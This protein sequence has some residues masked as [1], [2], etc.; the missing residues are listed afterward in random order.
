MGKNKKTVKE[1]LTEKKAAKATKAATKSAAKSA[2]ETKVETQAVEDPAPKETKE[3]KSKEKPATEAPKAETK[4]KKTS[5]KEKSGEKEEVLIPEE[6]KPEERKQGGISSEVS[7]SHVLN[8]SAGGAKID[9]NHAIDLMKMVREDYVSNPDVKKENPELAGVMV[10]QYEM[11]K[12]LAI[13]QYNAQVEEDFQKLG[14]KVTMPQF[15]EMEIIA[16]QTLGIQ[17]KSLPIPGNDKQL[18]ID[19]EGSEIPKE[20][21]EAARKEAKAAKLEIPEPDAKLPEAEKLTVLRTIFAQ[22]NGIGNNLAAA[23]E[24]ARK[25]FSFEETERKS[26]ILANIVNKGAGANMINC[27]RGMTIGK[28]NS[29]HSLL[30]AHALLKAWCPTYSDKEIAEI[31]QVLST[32]A[33]EKKIQDWNEKAD[34][35][36]KTTLDKELEAVHRQIIAGSTETIINAILNKKDK[37]IT[38]VKENS[39]EIAVDTASIRKSMVAAYGD[40]DNLLKDKLNEIVQYYVKPIMRL[41]NYVDKSAYAE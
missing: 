19:F 32:M 27:L 22:R 9:P 23:I 26:V 13:L 16:R 33:I 24:W 39:I 28:L 35:G 10:K 4:E 5:K 3:E 31:M 30:G 2:T 20:V 17:L 36:R 1:V 8:K 11:M 25:A 6:I 21:K 37:A 38:K 14:V 41:S 40:S 29:D 12:F 7:I 15:K 34:P 18:L